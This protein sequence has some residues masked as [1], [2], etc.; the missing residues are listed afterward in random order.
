MYLK[1]GSIFNLEK[2]LETLLKSRI[3][4]I[5]DGNLKPKSLVPEL[6]SVLSKAS[7]LTEN[8]KIRLRRIYDSA[9]LTS[10]FRVQEMSM[11]IRDFLLLSK[12]KPIYWCLSFRSVA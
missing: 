8:Y 12:A 4:P 10:S 11:R 9:A 5:L 1:T 6:E 2:H 3:G 7:K